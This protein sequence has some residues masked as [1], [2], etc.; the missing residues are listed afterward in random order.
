L[1]GIDFHA[2]GGS[3]TDGVYAYLPRPTEGE[4]PMQGAVAWAERLGAA[5]GEDYAA[6]EFA[7]IATYPSRWDTPGFS[8]YCAGTLDIPGLCIET[9]YAAVGDSLLTIEH[10][11]EIGRRMAEGILAQLA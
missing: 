1:L 5:L 11:R 6:P 10:Y 8:T 7:R 2:P 3:E 4:P 9:P